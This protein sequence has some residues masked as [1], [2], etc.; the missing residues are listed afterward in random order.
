MPDEP[1]VRLL[2]DKLVA[3]SPHVSPRE[4][5]KLA[6]VAVGASAQ[7]RRAYGINAPAR[8]HNFLVNARLKQR[9]LCH[10][11]A[12]DLMDHLAAVKPKTLDLHWGTAREGT[13]REHNA[14]V[15]TAR[16]Q[17]FAS[18]VVLDSWRYSGRLF[19]APVAADGY[20]WKEDLRD[21]L[22][23]ASRRVARQRTL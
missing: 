12:R 1:A 22:C 21:C 18:G 14:V 7:L 5:Q 11:W 16:G 13:L 3:L 20:P 9:G 10:H 2:R 23:V 8:F 6:R 4:A 17:P 19:S 15:V